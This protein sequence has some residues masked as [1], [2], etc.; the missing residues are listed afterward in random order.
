MSLMDCVLNQIL[1]HMLGYILDHMI[2][3]FM[4]KLLKL[5]SFLA[6]AL[7]NK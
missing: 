3:S 1:D 5:F 2:I 6:W 4:T 7:I